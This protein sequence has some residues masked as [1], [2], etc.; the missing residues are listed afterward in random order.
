M[1]KE[2]VRR[3]FFKLRG[4]G[5]SF[6]KCRILLAS[7]HGWQG[8]L[9][10]LERWSARLNA[11][12]WDLGDT[13]RR[14]FTIHRKVTPAVVQQVCAF[15]RKTGWG[16]EKIKQQY[17]DLPVSARTIK[18]IIKDQGLARQVKLRGKRIKWVRWQRHHPNSLWQVD[19]SDDQDANGT[20]TLS[21][22]DDNSRYSLSLQRLKHVTTDAVT[23]ILDDLTKTHGKPREILTDNGS[24]YGGT[25]K[26]SKFDR[27]CRKRGIIHIRASVHSPTTCGKVERLFQTIDNELPFCNNDQELFR[28]RY[29][30]HRPHASLNGKT[31]AQVYLGW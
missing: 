8:C 9:R 21:V 6:S 22:L 24:A 31:P 15:R 23:R 17:P 19:H 5:I 30:H 20:W 25:S 29:N 3:E 4:K 28:M 11:G 18:R 26:H 14:P 27:W 7:Q 10:T 1:R 12:G 2:E 16:H 13:S